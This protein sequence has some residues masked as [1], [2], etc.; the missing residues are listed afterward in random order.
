M[1]IKKIWPLIGTE[2]RVFINETQ[3][4]IKKASRNDGI[5]NKNK[6]KQNQ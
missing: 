1:K 3:E 6:T 4:Y 5:K 2:Q